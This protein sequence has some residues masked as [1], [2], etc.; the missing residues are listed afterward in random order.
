MMKQLNFLKG[1]LKH[2]INYKYLLLDPDNPRF[3]VTVEAN[4]K[5]KTLEEIKDLQ[6]QIIYKIKSNKIAYLKL[7]NSLLSNGY[8]GSESIVIQKLSDS[9]E[10]FIVREGNRRI[11]AIKEILKNEKKR[12]QLSR[13]QLKSLEYPTCYLIPAE[14]NQ[15]EIYQMLSARHI[16]GTKPWGLSER[17]IAIAELYIL[18]KK[19]FPQGRTDKG[20]TILQ[21]LAK[22]S[23]ISTS[24]TVSNFLVATYLQKEVT[25]YATEK[26]AEIKKNAKK[27]LSL[28]D[29]KNIQLDLYIEA[30]RN[31]NFN[32]W[33]KLERIQDDYLNS[34]IH[35]KEN[36]GIYVS[37][38]LKGIITSA[39]N[40]QRYFFKIIQEEEKLQEL[41]KK[42]NYYYE[43]QM[44]D[45]IL[46]LVYEEF[47]KLETNKSLILIERFKHFLD[48]I[49][50]NTFEKNPSLKEELQE[51]FF[52]LQKILK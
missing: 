46:R 6:E 28:K 21:E 12:K 35:N 41:L 17:G 15:I 23:G 39:R 26:Y 22:R 3:Q 47:V 1:E 9:N 42:I 44:G 7:E 27:V 37:Y 2:N 11:A 51:I 4:R 16:V 48:N 32:S 52:S 10:Y 31:H 50:I 34:R 25:K 38:I 5:T 14:T 30:V 45:N 13:I 18:L 49:S 43:Y 24:Q 29:L 33:I 19:E 40:H 8:I 36:F 20:L